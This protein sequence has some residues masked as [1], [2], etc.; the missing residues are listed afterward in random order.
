MQKINDFLN[1]L[2]PSFYV[3]LGVFI[4]GVFSI[5]STYLNDK[6][7][8]SLKIIENKFLKEK[9]IFDKKLDIFVE[10]L[11]RRSKLHCSARKLMENQEPIDAVVNSV[12]KLRILIPEKKI[13]LN[14]LKDILISLSNEYI[15]S[16]RC[17]KNQN[18]VE[19]RKRI[20]AINGIRHSFYEKSNILIDYM[21]NQVN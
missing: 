6:H 8:R 16:D 10:F 18:T 17:H 20:E 3:L 2:P 14:D 7:S 9:E 4:S 21:S 5:L 15:L 11:D 13:E 1:G 12:Y 19:Y